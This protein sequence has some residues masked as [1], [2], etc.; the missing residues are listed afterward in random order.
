MSK[1]KGELEL[2]YIP[3]EELILLEGNPKLHDM[4]A[5]AASIVENGFRDPPIWDANLNGGKGGIVA[6]NGRSET[7][8]HLKQQ[9]QS[10]PRGIAVDQQGN[11]YV[12]VIFGCD[13]RSEAAAKRFAIDHNN[14][15]MAGGNFTALDMSKLW[16]ETAY[17]AL[18]EELAAHDSLPLTVDGDDLDLMIKLAQQDDATAEEDT[19]L[20]A[21]ESDVVTFT[22]GEIRIFVPKTEYIKWFDDLNVRFSF[23][24]K[25]IADHIKQVLGIDV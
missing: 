20:E 4:G 1:P 5:I 6:G 23:N 17:T 16:D 8:M 24:K 15:V 22:I 21:G 18:L 11:W 3:L 2:R 9:G 12:P 7:L 19:D 10:P 13:A 14:L 25:K